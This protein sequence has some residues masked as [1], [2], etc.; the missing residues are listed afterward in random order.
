MKVPPTILRRRE[1]NFKPQE[2]YWSSFLGTELL[3]DTKIL[4]KLTSVEPSEISIATIKQLEDIFEK[5]KLT[6]DR[7]ASASNAA[8][9][10]FKWTNAIRTYYFVYQDALPARNKIIKADL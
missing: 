3:G 4:Q 1:D 6:E 2:C 9:G 7:V 8:R 5:Q 10:L